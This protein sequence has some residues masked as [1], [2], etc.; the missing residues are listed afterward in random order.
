MKE[1]SYRF[2][3]GRYNDS[4]NS[5]V[6]FRIL[7]ARQAKHRIR[8]K[9]LVIISFCNDRIMPRIN[10]IMQQT[11]ARQLQEDNTAPEHIIQV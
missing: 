9:Q 8:P 6:Q 4:C 11:F 10:T 5:K 2:Q 3:T 7:S 1:L